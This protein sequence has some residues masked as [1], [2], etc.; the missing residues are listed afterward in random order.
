MV[1]ISKLPGFDRVI[2][3]SSNES[4]LGPSPKAIAAASR[5]MAEAHRYPEVETEALRSALAETFGLEAARITFGA[6][7]DELLTRLVNTYCGNGDEVIH[8]EHA[9]MQFPIYAKTAGAKPVAARDDDFRHSVD[10]ILACVTPRTKAV[11]V[12]NPDNPSGT[13]L[14][15]S[16]IRRLADG[17]PKDVLLIIDAAYDEYAWAE[18]FESA[19]K[20]VEERE[21][22]VTTRTFSKVFGL[23]GLRLGWCYAAPSIVDLLERIGPSFPVNSAAREAALAALADQAHT[24]SVLDH[25][26]RVGGQF[27]ADLSALGLKVYPSQ[28]NFVLVAFP[29]E[30]SHS[31]TAADRVLQENGI[32]ARRFAVDDFKDKLR[33]TI[34]LEPE[35]QKTVA[36]LRDFLAG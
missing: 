6:G 21:N 18:D 14:P 2:K 25:N 29:T 16:E 36:V 13:Y 4:P 7:S 17:L 1:G 20:L 35:M 9:Y 19:T 34:G 28:T 33:F 30:E 27:A 26:R 5:A 8:S 32:I 15:G 23:A 22:V 11:I 12:A 3:L 10:N 31:A 24:Q